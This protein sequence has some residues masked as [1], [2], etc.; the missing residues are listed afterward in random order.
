MIQEATGAAPAQAVRE[1]LAGNY[2]GTLMADPEV[3]LRIW[4]LFSLDLD[5]KN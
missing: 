5:S 2:F 1:R 4:L 3:A